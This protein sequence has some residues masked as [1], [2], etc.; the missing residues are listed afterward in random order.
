MKY[1]QILQ[2]IAKDIAKV[3]HESDVMSQWPISSVRVLYY[4]GGFFIPEIEKSITSWKND[5]VS[6]FEQELMPGKL[7][8]LVFYFLN[9]KLKEMMGGENHRTLL[10]TI[11]S[12]IMTFKNDSFYENYTAASWVPEW[13]LNPNVAM[14][15]SRELVF[16]LDNLAEIVNPIFRSFGFQLF[17]DDKHVYRYYYRLDLNQKIIVVSLKEGMKIDFFEHIINP[18]NLDRSQIYIDKNGEISNADMAEILEIVK[19]KIVQLKEKNLFNKEY[20]IK[21]IYSAFNYSIPAP[22]KVF[23]QSQ[24]PKEIEEFYIKTCRIPEDKLSRILYEA[25]GGSN[26]S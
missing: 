3:Q 25:L 19:G 10:K 20:V 24:F 17:F 8:G 2:N 9:E 11:I 22:Q 16:L 21:Q 1:P 4:S 13:N 15:D 14:V 18:E 26:D 7:A 5:P 23:I 12:K 6:L